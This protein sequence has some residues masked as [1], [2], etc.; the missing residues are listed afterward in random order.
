MKYR[1]GLLEHR[2]T[3]AACEVVWTHKTL[4][5]TAQS[6]LHRTT[7]RPG[8]KYIG[9]LIAVLDSSFTLLSVADGHRRLVR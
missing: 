1:R 8:R 5:A 3:N 4:I 6:D 7:T 2:P 9:K